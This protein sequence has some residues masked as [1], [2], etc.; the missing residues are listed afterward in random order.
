MTEDQSH[1]QDLVEIAI[2]RYQSK[3]IDRRTLIGTLGAIGV[4]PLLFK[5]T[6]ASAQASELIVV[7]WGGPAVEAYQI[8]FGQG[9]EKKLDSRS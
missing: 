5:A 1:T 9:S 3:R 2:D 8:A 7:N 6:A 4:S